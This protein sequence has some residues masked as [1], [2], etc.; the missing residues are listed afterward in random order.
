VFEGTDKIC[1]W[2]FLSFTEIRV[3]DKVGFY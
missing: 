2:G 1:V 3:S